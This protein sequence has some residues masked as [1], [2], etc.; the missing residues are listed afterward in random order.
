MSEKKKPTID[1]IPTEQLRDI[2]RKPSG[3]LFDFKPDDI[4]N[5]HEMNEK[6]KKLIKYFDDYGI[7][8][9]KLDED[10]VK[11]AYPNYDQYM[12]I[13]GQHNI[14]KWLQTVRQ[15][16]AAEKNGLTRAQAVR[17]A[18]NGWNIMETYDFLNWI[19]FYQEGAHLKYKTAQL[20]YENGQPGYFLQIKPDAPKEPEP[21]VDHNAVDNAREDVERQEEKKKVIEKQRQKIVGRLD[22]AE[23]LL[24]SPEGQLF[25]GP[26]MEGLMEAIFSLKKKVQL[27]NKLSTSTRLYEDMIVREGNVLRRKGFVKA[28]EVLYSMAQANNPPP[29]GTGTPG[30]INTPPATPPPDDPSGAG[31]PGAPGGLPSLGPG[32]PQPPGSPPTGVSET[33]PVNPKSPAGPPGAVAE[34]PASPMPQEPPKGIAEFLE[35]TETAGKTVPD[36]KQGVDD[37][38][39]V[40]DTLEVEDEVLMVTEAQM[41]PPDADVPMTT[42]PSKPKPPPPPPEAPP[43]PDAPSAAP[44]LEVT[45]DTPPANEAGVEDAAGPAKDFDRIID[46][47]LANVTVADVVAKLED[48]TKIFKTREIPRQLSLVDMMLDSLGL[49]SY[50]PKLSEAINK[51]LESNNYVSTRLDEI[52]SQLRGSMKGR[53][54][55]LKGEH[56]ASRAPEVAQNLQEQSEKEESRKKMR[57]EQENAELQGNAP[58]AGKESPQVEIGEDLGAQPAAPPAAPAAGPPV[59]RPLG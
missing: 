22:S 25:A 14:N 21:T 8:Y 46:S 19:K 31:H 4:E 16:Y 6:I 1:P 24:R 36:D 28:A 54:V 10:N 12:S 50:F 38:L 27:V 32:M 23:K 15:I 11:T 58:G 51:S 33:Q 13:P 41:A 17:Q 44:P 3:G 37:D 39:E 29:P 40:E 2:V 48:I 59:P 26:E 42:T 47:A 53:D 57:K 52:L 30:P 20:W 43:A 56:G 5:S 34:G 35:G 49:S 18:T 7:D 45:D 55:D 9:N